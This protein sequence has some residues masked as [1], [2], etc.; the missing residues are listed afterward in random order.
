MVDG[1]MAIQVGSCY[2]NVTKP[3]QAICHANSFAA[4]EPGRFGMAA[5]PPATKTLLHAYGKIMTSHNRRA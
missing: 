4:N 3:L 2:R 5:Y 1:V